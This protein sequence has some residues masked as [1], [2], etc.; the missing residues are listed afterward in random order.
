MEGYQR[1]RNSQAILATDL[2]ALQ[3]H[4]RNLKE[5]KEMKTKIDHLENEIQDLKNIV[6]QL[7]KERSAW[8]KK[9]F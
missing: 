8:R 1:E 3:S 5:K 2:K 4:R 6:N 9:K 7:L